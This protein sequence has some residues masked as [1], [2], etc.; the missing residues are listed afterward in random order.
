[1]GAAIIAT[2]VMWDSKTTTLKTFATFHK[3][4]KICRCVKVGILR[5]FYKCGA[6]FLRYFRVGW[7]I[8]SLTNLPKIRFPTVGQYGVFFFDALNERRHEAHFQKNLV[9]LAAFHSLCCLQDVI[10]VTQK[11]ALHVAKVIPVKHEEG[12]LPR[13]CRITVIPISLS[14]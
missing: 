6:N 10:N 12:G 7:R 3:G 4:S 11:T 1:M 9:Q 13:T 14:D 5:T 8:L 2:K